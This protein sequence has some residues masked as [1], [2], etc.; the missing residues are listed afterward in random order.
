[1][2]MLFHSDQLVVK[3][4]ATSMKAL[5]DTLVELTHRST[6][7]D[8]IGGGGVPILWM[9]RHDDSTGYYRRCS[10]RSMASNIL[11]CL[12]R[13]LNG[14]THR[15][16]TFQSKYAPVPQQVSTRVVAQTLSNLNYTDNKLVMQKLKYRPN[17]IIYIFQHARFARHT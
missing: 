10:P 5:C 11:D 2:W 13:T 7:P 9:A 15:P 14:K 8:L 16:I 4:V 12:Q 17:F 1:M 6:V 3:M